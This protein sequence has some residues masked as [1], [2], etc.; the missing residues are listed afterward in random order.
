MRKNQIV[1]GGLG[2]LAGVV[3]MAGTA[4]LTRPGAEP[5]VTLEA[6]EVYRVP[7]ADRAPPAPRPSVP[8][9]AGE[10][11]DVDSGEASE[12]EALRTEVAWLRGMVDPLSGPPPAW[13]EREVYHPDTARASVEAAFPG[14]DIAMDCREF[15]CVAVI[16]T[17]P[18]VPEALAED[19][20][21]NGEVG[22]YLAAAGVDDAHLTVRSNVMEHG[23]YR[24]LVSAIP[25]SRESELGERLRARFEMLAEFGFEE[26]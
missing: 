8:E 12:V 20:S 4:E 24:I 1:A 13:P 11:T 15:P 3:V 25:S 21:R 9:G 26:R 22:A 17:G 7:V 19:L 5:A 10:G 6:G 23:G 2:A 18:D 14:S 16:E